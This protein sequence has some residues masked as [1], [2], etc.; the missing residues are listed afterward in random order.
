[1]R[2]RGPS[3]QFVMPRLDRGIHIAIFL[4]ALVLPA[5][6]SGISE[7]HYNETMRALG[8]LETR[9]REIISAFEHMTASEAASLKPEFDEKLI[10]LRRVK[11]EAAQTGVATSHTKLRSALYPRCIVLRAGRLDPFLQDL[12]VNLALRMQDGQNTDYIPLNDALP[13]F[14]D[15]SDGVCRIEN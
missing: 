15:A 12:T 13:L 14:L 7:A 1:M 4:I 8:R 2:N 3:L 10:W 5:S 11:A 6:A 9:M